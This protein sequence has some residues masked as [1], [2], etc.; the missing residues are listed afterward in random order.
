MQMLGPCLR[1]DQRLRGGVVAIDGGAV[2]VALGQADDLSAFEVDCGKDDQAHI[3]IRTGGEVGSRT[4]LQETGEEGKAI[5][6]ALFRMKLATDDRVAR[7]GSHQRA[8]MI[9]DGRDMGRVGSFEM[10][11]VQEIGFAADQ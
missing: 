4:P 8:A 11:A 7:D 5:G 1:E 10:I 6:L 2:H 9:G 3:N